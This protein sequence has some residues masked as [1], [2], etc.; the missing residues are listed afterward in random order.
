M[1]GDEIRPESLGPRLGTPRQNG[2]WSGRL[3]AIMPAPVYGGTDSE[4]SEN[5]TIYREY[6]DTYE[7]YR[8]DMADDWAFARH[9]RHWTDAEIAELATNGQ[10]P[11]V[12]NHAGRILE[13]YAA[14]VAGRVA[15]STVL[16]RVAGTI[17]LAEVLGDILKY[18]YHISRMTTLSPAVVMESLGR[19]SSNAFVYFDQNADYGRGDVVIGHPS[20]F[21]IL[22]D[23]S[24]RDPLGETAEHVLVSG[25]RAKA[26][27][28]QQY[29]EHRE[30]I[31]SAAPDYHDEDYQSIDRGSPLN[32]RGWAWGDTIRRNRDQ[33]RFICRYT[34]ILQEHLMLEDP[35]T[36]DAMA[37]LPAT[38]EREA[39]RMAAE[40]D[41]MIGREF[42]DSAGVEIPIRR[43]NV[44]RVREVKSLTTVGTRSKRKSDYGGYL[45]EDRVVPISRYPIVPF[46]NNFD[47]SPFSQSEVRILK[48]PNE[49]FNK[50]MSLG[51]KQAT[52]LASGGKVLVHEGSGAYEEMQQKAGKPN[53]VIR[54][55][56]EQPWQKPELM[57]PAP[58]S[59][60]PITLAQL[61]QRFMDSTSGMFQELQGAG[62]EARES[63]RLRSIR[64]EESSQRPDQKLKAIE[65]AWG[66]VGEVA[67][68]MAQAA[69]RGPKVFSISDT[70]NEIRTMAVN[71]AGPNGARVHRTFSG[72][73]VMGSL[74]AGRYGV[75]VAPGSTKPTSRGERFEEAITLRTAGVPIP[76]DVILEAWDHPKAREVAARMGEME[77]M[78]QKIQ[79][80]Q[81]QLEESERRRITAETE[82]D[83]A[84]RAKELE[85]TRGDLETLMAQFKARL[86]TIE[87]R[88]ESGA[89]RAQADIRIA[90]ADAERTIRAAE[91]AA[92]AEPTG[93]P[94]SRPRGRGNRGK[95]ERA[96]GKAARTT[97][98]GARGR[99]RA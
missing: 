19:G 54:W 71:Q 14:R 79:Q 73:E 53:A 68:E 27:L 98:G 58:F 85:Q 67:I 81:Q 37:L 21:E 8:K 35:L 92:T 42:P 31:E 44:W 22:W 6:R 87:S 38:E 77:Q 11:I 80:L 59:E 4:A 86:T 10:A 93:S 32:Q 69:Y 55:R 7:T 30:A 16:P 90:Q 84:R 40:W 60:A 24:L 56:G 28:A 96:S 43:V 61:A 78:G 50:M 99:S 97:G 76:N 15:Q 18:I 46:F 20:A 72:R 17:E 12:F 13:Q 70:A 34:R 29:P 49:F 51:V 75:V 89:V 64:N 52:G 26:L 3:K 5:Y 66:V 65:A 45:I 33:V 39:R 47:G 88:V 91:E 57:P 62:G 9:G 63:A 1:P 83:R 2:T 94:G 74:N 82:T 95:N 41:A 36:G 23:P 48:S 25:L